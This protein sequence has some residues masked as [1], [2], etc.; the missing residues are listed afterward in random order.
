MELPGGTAFHF[1]SYTGN[2]A[3]HMAAFR[4]DPAIVRELL[5]AGSDVAASNN[6]GDTPLHFAAIQ[7]PPAAPCA[8]YQHRTGLGT[9]GKDS[10]LLTDVGVGQGHSS[11]MQALLAAGADVQARQ[12]GG[13]QPLH[14]AA[15]GGSVAA[16]QA[17]L[18]AG[19]SVESREGNGDT[20][21]HTAARQGHAVRRPSILSIMCMS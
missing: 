2:T 20:A 12:A 6:R 8:L 11:A 17:A 1:D 7:V 19:A 3:L 14:Y 5:V 13:D 18:A 9:F 4:G 21:L 10:H 15:H 16:V